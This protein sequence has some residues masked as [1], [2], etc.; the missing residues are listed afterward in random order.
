MTG[1]GEALINSLHRWSHVA[2]AQRWAD[3]WVDG[4]ILP[5]EMVYFLARCDANAIDTIIESGRQDGYSTQILGEFMKD[6]PHMRVYS[7]DWEEDPERARRCRERLAH[8]ERLTLKNGD[9][10]FLIP[11]LLRENRGRRVGL[12]VDGPKGFWAVSLLFASLRFEEVKLIALHNLAVGTGYREFLESVIE[13]PLFY[14]RYG[15]GSEVWT[16]LGH[17][18]VPVVE[19]IRPGWGM[20]ESTLG[21]IEVTDEV[22]RT[23]RKVGDKRFRLFPP[24]LVGLGWKMGADWLVSKLFSL[25]FRIWSH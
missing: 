9:A 2:L 5:R 13:K 6:K 24:C 20:N 18:E 3:K 8:Y 17:Q 4:A 14:E 16:T 21:V 23:A 15:I 11:E 1:N 7:I 10:N 19:G 22:R 12:L 25:S